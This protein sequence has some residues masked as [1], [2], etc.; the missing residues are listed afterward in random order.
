MSTNE[1]SNIRPP[2]RIVLSVVLLLVVQALLLCYLSWS[3]SPNRTE[4][5][6]LGAAV[7]FWHT[8]K[9]DVFNVNPPLVRVVAGLPI[10]LFCNP[11]YDLTTYSPRPQDRCEWSLGHSFVV[12]NNFDDVRLYVFLTRLACI[13]FVLLGGWF[14]YRFASELYGDLSGVLF[15]ILWTFSPFILGWG[16]TIC[17][18]AAAASMGIVGLYTFWHWLKKPTWQ[19][20]IVAGICLGLMPLTKMTWIIAPV[21]W[22]MLWIVRRYVFRDGVANRAKPPLRQL[23]VMM[24][25]ALYV[26]NTGYL[27]DGTFRLLGS[28]KFISGTLTN[29]TITHGTPF[30]IGNRFSDSILGYVPVPLPAEFVQGIDTQ[31]RDFEVGIE[32]YARGVWADSG[33]WWY[34]CYVLLLKE[35]LGVW[36]LTILATFATILSRRL[37]TVWRDEV[38][39]LLPL[40]TV[41]IFVSSQDGFSIHPRYIILILPLLYIFISKTAACLTC[42]KTALK[43]LMTGGVLASALWIVASSMSF[44]PHS[45]SYFNELGGN[46]KEWSNYLQ[47]SNID[48]GQDLYELKT[49]CEKN[50]DK[51]PCYITVE[52]SLPLETLNIKH[53]GSVPQTQTN[54]WMII[55][56]NLIN[57]RSGKYEWLKNH[58]PKMM[59]GYTIWIYEIIL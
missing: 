12:A 57:D 54:G 3:T 36:V 44:Y 22:L 1:I 41:F 45:L 40:F 47:G 6:H 31:K 52:Q 20:T 19:Q 5:G 46:P 25:V 30:K 55:G 28:Y 58:E 9:F 4:V 35:P 50:Q 39:I 24:F 11:K 59:I 33:W 7:Y 2:R 37:N 14:G 38:T 16:A 29:T 32:S 27:F 18:D 34:Y 48:W 43:L 15:L 26:I 13:P 23:A 56:V 42:G 8:G 10:A 49:W 51:Q 53:N 17:P 21:L